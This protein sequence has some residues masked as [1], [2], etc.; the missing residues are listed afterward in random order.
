MLTVLYVTHEYD[1]MLGST[2]SLL[3][4][5]HSVRA[6]VKPI[7]L[8]PFEGAVSSVLRKMGIKCII[9]RFPLG[10]TDKHG[11]KYLGAYGPRKIRDALLHHKAFRQIDRQLEGINIDI[12]H[13]NSSVI[14]F[15]HLL[16]LRY[17][18]PHVWHLREFIDLFFGFK[19]FGGW[20]GFYRKL[21][22]SDAIIGISEAVFNH[23]AKQKADESGHILYDAV[24]C[25]NDCRFDSAKEPYFM[26]CGALTKNKGVETGLHAFALFNRINKSYKLLLIGNIDPA[27]RIKLET[28]VAKLNLEGKVEFIGHTDNIDSYYSKATGLLMCS[29]NEGLGRVTIEAMF[30]GC[31]VIGY[32]DGAT[33]EIIGDGTS[34]YLFDSVED[35]A[36]KMNKVTD[37]AEISR[38]A[39]N[40]HLRARQMF[41]EE[42]MSNRLIEIYHSAINNYFNKSVKN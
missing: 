5:I 34:G 3:N 40:A 20:K 13:T 32:R 29:R 37:P 39:H 35:C 25:A 9:A 23:Y 38:L 12:I 24:R 10:I 31:P 8:L 21:Y 22:A 1:I 18:K 7:V 26:M 6:E 19:P 16:A 27:Y 33:K 28:L 36:E 11:L 4:M 42:A 17:N 41:S 30:N 15:G 14:D 2:H